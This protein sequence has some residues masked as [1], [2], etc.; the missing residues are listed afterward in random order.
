M[1]ALSLSSNRI[2]LSSALLGFSISA[3]ADISLIDEK[4]YQADFYGK[5]KVIGRYQS[6]T[7]EFKVAD[8]SSRFGIKGHWD[9]ELARVYS[10]IEI[11][12]H[13]NT[14]ADDLLSVRLLYAGLK[15]EAGQ[16]DFGKQEAL[17]HDLDN[18]D[19]S[20]KLGG[21]AHITRESLGNQ[22]NPSTL[23][24]RT[25]SGDWRLMAQYN[26][27]RSIDKSIRLRVGS[28]S[29]GA[30]HQ[31][32]DNGWSVGARYR[33]KETGI[34]LRGAVQMTSFKENANATSMGLT[35]VKKAELGGNPVRFSGMISHYEL[36]DH[37]ETGQAVGI[38]GG[39][40]W[41]A[42]E[43][44]HA[45][46]VIENLQ[47]SKDLSEGK[48]TSATLG[49]EYKG[50]ENIKLYTE[51]QRSWFDAAKPDQWQFALGAHYEF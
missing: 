41:E 47:G 49:V 6:H 1:K 30:R 36:K 38:G 34:A 46:S 37:S 2:L 17:V 28:Q 32:I 8:D 40:K 13:L 31:A 51:S 19:F 5:A 20:N 3:T 39:I 50:F 16:V 23:S 27:S 48:E 15:N 44:F 11:G 21:A 9:T 45:Y 7:S 26:F 43:H 10:K 33:D 42:V 12:T 24:V 4:D 25:D 22:R 29:V 14:G 18:Y 35:A